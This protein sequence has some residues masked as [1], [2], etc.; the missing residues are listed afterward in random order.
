MNEEGKYDEDQ[1]FTKLNPGQR[2]FFPQEKSRARIEKYHHRM[3][4]LDQDIELLGNFDTSDASLLAIEV[5]L[6]DNRTTTCRK[7]V[8]PDFSLEE[9]FTRMFLVSFSNSL[10]FNGEGFETDDSDERFTKE[11]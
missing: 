5:Q 10:V 1:D 7:D 3:M 2:L 6:C 9:H 8:D 11:S 4:C